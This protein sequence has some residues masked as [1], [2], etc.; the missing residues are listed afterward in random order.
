MHLAYRGCRA[1]LQQLSLD[2]LPAALENAV[3]CTAGNCGNSGRLDKAQA[4]LLKRY[5]TR[6]HLFDKPEVQHGAL[7]F[8]ENVIQRHQDRTANA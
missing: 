8:V 5:Q 1:F 6:L 4:D 7:S 2:L 3:A